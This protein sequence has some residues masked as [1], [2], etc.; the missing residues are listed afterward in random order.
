LV[1]LQAG[2][3]KIEATGLAVVAISYD[4]VTDLERFSEHKH[5][6]FPLLADPESQTIVAYGILN[7]EA[8]KA[9]VKG[10]PHPGIF[11]IDKQGIVRSKLFHEGYRVRPSV[12]ELV[13]AGLAIK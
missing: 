6:T 7:K 2:L 11:V 5:I 9:P 13:E 12:D 3:G 1:Q 8:T 4:P 10:T